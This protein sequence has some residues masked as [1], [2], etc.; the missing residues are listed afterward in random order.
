MT[1][2]PNTIEFFKTFPNILECANVLNFYGYEDE[3]EC[4]VYEGYK[5]MPDSAILN[6]TSNNFYHAFY[7]GKTSHGDSY[8]RRVY[9]DIK[10][11]VGWDNFRDTCREG[12]YTYRWYFDPFDVLI[13]SGPYAKIAPE[14]ANT[15]AELDRLVRLSTKLL[16]KWCDRLNDATPLDYQPEDIIN[17]EIEFYRSKAN[18]AVNPS[19]LSF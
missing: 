5:E 9:E 1:T 7:W 8:W 16:A 4:L 6:G 13:D 15:S 11:S 12:T 3:A 10:R 14:P 18:K 2:D 17:L 19:S